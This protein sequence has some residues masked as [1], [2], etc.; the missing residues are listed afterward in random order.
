VTWPGA[1]ERVDRHGP[2]DGHDAAV[3]RDGECEEVRVACASP[4]SAALRRGWARLL[5]RVYEIDRLIC[6][7]SQ[8]VK[9]VVSFMTEGRV[10]RRV[11][12]HLGASASPGHLGSG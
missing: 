9:R 10:I 5:R 7:R 11:L 2:V 1:G 6:P 12:D 3:V 4:S 8:G